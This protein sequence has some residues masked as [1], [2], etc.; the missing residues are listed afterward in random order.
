MLKATPVITWPTP[1]AITYGT[2]LSGTQLNAT[3]PAG[4]AGTFVYTPASGAVLG[5]GAGQ[6]LVGDLHADRHRELQHRDRD[7][8]RSR[9]SRRRR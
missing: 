4:I 6:T 2:A 7:G 1:A 8:R 3:A 9:W 5:A